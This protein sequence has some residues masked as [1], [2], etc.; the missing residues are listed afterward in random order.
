MGVPI[1]GH[2]WGAIILG[3][4]YRP[5]RNNND[6]NSIRGFNNEFS[7][8]LNKVTKLTKNTTITGDFNINL[9][10]LNEREAYGEFLDLMITPGVGVWVGG[11][12]GGGGVGGWGWGV[13]HYDVPL[14]W[15]TFGDP[16]VPTYGYTFGERSLELGLIF[17][18]RPYNW[19][20]NSVFPVILVT[21][22]T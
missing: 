7:T 2:I 11:W 4:V 9:L 6:N 1:S 8:V 3:N 18:H 5:P 13:G 15:V 20:P 16:R 19:G 22:D 12:G 17:Y 21:R 10:E 14:K